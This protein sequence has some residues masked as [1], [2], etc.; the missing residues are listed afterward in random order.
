[1]EYPTGLKHSLILKISYQA[2]ALTG[3]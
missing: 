2:K 1:M 3:E